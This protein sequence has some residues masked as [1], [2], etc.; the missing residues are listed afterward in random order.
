MYG[1]INFRQLVYLLFMLILPTAL[2]FLPSMLAEQAKQGAW[3]SITFASLFGLIT[4]TVIF[5]LDKRF[6]DKNLIEINEIL[7][8]KAGRLIA[9]LIISITIIHTD[10]IIIREYMEF[11]GTAILPRT[12]MWIFTLFKLIIVVYALH[13][14]L[15][16]IARMADFITPIVIIF[17][18]IFLLFVLR[19]AHGVNLLPIFGTGIKDILK[20]S[21]APSAW[22]SQIFMASFLLPY[23][24]QKNKKLFTLYLSV[25]LITLT[26]LFSVM[27]VIAVVGV[28]MAGRVTMPLFKA[29]A[30]GTT[31]FFEHLDII[32]VS[33]WI[34]GA[35]IKI[36]VFSYV[37]IITLGQTFKIENEKILILP[38]CLLMGILSFAYFRH[39]VEIF[40]YIKNT[41]LYHFVLISFVMPLFLLFYSFIR[42]KT[43]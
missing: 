30:L 33:I 13:S 6:P 22:F 37:G 35:T 43:L 18:F 10:V 38:I 39:Q 15:E 26:L 20:G 14:G 4:A 9:G 7:F 28:N 21:I 1:I 27:S 11:I 29:S 32:F 36:I 2:L 8:G 31:L 12:P 40:H 34:L 23:I 16:I 41:L 24:K 25:L 3:L 5:L 17:T 19:N 42:K